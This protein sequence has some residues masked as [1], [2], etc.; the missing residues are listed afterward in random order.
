MKRKRLKDLIAWKNRPDR[1]PLMLQ[2]AR[3]V[4]KTY[5]LEQ[6]GKEAFPQTHRLNFEKKPE[7]CLLFDLDLDPIRLVKELSLFLGT[8]IDIHRDLLIFDE[9]QACPKAITSLKYFCEDMPELALCSAGS[10]LGIHLTPTSYP[11]GKVDLMSLFPMCFEEF[12]LALGDQKFLEFMEEP[13]DSPLPEF[14]HS[15]LWNRLKH[16]FVVG[17]LPEVVQTYINHQNSPVEAFKQVRKRQNEL[18]TI[19]YADMAK[20]CGA[21]NAMHIQRVWNSVP[22]QL[23]RNLDGSSSKYVFK[24]VIPQVN[25]YQ[26][27]VGAIDWLEAAGLIIKISIVESAQIPLKA[28][29]KENFFKLM[30]FDIG[31]LGAMSDLSA[32]S[33]LDYEYGSYK[34]YFAENFVAQE[35]LQG[36]GKPLYSWNEGT[37]E[38]EF[39]VDIEGKIIPVEVKSGEVTHSKSLLS[40]SHKYDPLYSVI[41]SGKNFHFNNKKRR[42]FY[43]LY[44]AGRILKGI[45][46]PG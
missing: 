27:L 30:L 23:M 32:Q 41:L 1:K 26:Q 37:A 17:G 6:F 13:K 4:G 25:R 33:I 20:H 28:Y 22:T 16:Y 44:L 42:Y 8:D 46:L 36:A 15:H 5:L 9:I 31:I 11:V 29:N 35:F 12:L 39:L 43:P 18:I 34:G 3:Q 21:V 10:L 7:A 38:V 40:F 24:G 45:L 14:V 19:Y 2:G